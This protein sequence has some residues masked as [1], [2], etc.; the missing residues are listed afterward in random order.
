M[1]LPIGVCVAPAPAL[2]AART[3]LYGTYISEILAH[4]GLPHKIIPADGLTA[5]LHE[6]G[7]LVTIGEV[8]LTEDARAAVERWVSGGCAWIAVAGLCGMADFLGVQPEPPPFQSWGGGP[9]SRRTSGGRSG[10]PG[11]STRRASRSRRAGVSCRASAA[12]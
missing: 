11:G 1:R 6:I 3:S 7:I 8:V 4:A 9:G 10:P 5:R 12:A 2:N